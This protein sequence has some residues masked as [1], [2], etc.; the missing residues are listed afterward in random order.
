MAHLVEKRV[1]LALSGITKFATAGTRTVRGFASTDS[2]DR[3]G[4]IVEPKGGRWSLPVPLLWQHD[5]SSPV[6]WVRSIEVRAQGLW[7]EAQFAEGLGKS[8][9]IWKMVEGG[10]VSSYSIG[11]KASDWEQLPTGGRRFTKWELLEVSAVVIPAN[12]DAKIQRHM[13]GIKLVDP[14]PR[15]ERPPVRLFQAPKD[16]RW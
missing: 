4:D 15:I 13:P 16:R 3:V 2:V 7:I 10:L 1:E 11:F 12:P 14:K 8:D 9:E 5:H 6:G